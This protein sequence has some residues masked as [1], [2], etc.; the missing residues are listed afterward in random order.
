MP[1][2]IVSTKGTALNRLAT[3]PPAIGSG[4]KI[5]QIIA[6]MTDCWPEDADR[7]HEYLAHPTLYP[8]EDVAD[9][10]TQYCRANNLG[11]GVSE[12]SVRRY[13]K[14]IKETA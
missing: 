1:K 2:L 12:T 13:R 11:P 3:I 4:A 6:H 5:P 7:L 14:N 10:L 8:H 9:A